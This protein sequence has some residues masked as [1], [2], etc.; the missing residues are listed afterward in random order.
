MG[1][2]EM[3]FNTQIGGKE[4]GKGLSMKFNNPIR[5]LDKLS[6]SLYRKISDIESQ[7]DLEKYMKKTYEVLVKMTISKVANK[8][9]NQISDGIA[10]T[11]LELKDKNDS[12]PHLLIGD[13]KIRIRNEKWQFNVKSIKAESS[14]GYSLLMVIYPQ[15]DIYF[16]RNSSLTN[17]IDPI[18]IANYLYKNLPTTEAL[19]MEVI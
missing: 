5:T 14:G 8:T 18:D 10:D 13:N 15:R 19:H 7:S 3:L 17:P 4:G 9:I 16:D 11:I 6:L 2:G 12:I 1:S